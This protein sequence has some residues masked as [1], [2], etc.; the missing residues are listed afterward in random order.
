MH[1]VLDGQDFA[2]VEV[3]PLAPFGAEV[4]SLVTTKRELEHP[5]LLVAMRGKMSERSVLVF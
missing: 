3:P 5:N 1:V 2:K 4:R